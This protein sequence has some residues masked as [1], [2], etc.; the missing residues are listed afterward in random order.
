MKKNLLLIAGLLFTFGVAN[1]QFDINVEGSSNEISGMSHTVNA[2]SVEGLEVDFMIHNTGNA[3]DYKVTRKRLDVPAGWADYLC[4]G[5][6]GDATGGNCY[7]AS[8][9][10]TNPWSTPDVI[11]LNPSETGVLLVHVDPDDNTYGTAH[12]RYYMGRTPENPLDS[13]DLIISTSQLGVKVIKNPS[14]VFSVFPNPAV[15]FL[16]VNINT[17]SADNFLR[18]SDVLGKVVYEEKISGSK[19]INTEDF[20]NGVYVVTLTSNGTTYTKRLV[21]KH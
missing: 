3:D 12:Y 17:N 6:E 18:I 9:M 7:G 13:V 19:K 4:W 21:V 10:N 5:E 20:K 8:Q 11:N 1:A 15:D 16:S 14:P 2:V